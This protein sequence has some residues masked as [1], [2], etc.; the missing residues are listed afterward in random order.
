MIWMK[1]TNEQ[2]ELSTIWYD[3]IV[4]GK[5]TSQ[6]RFGEAK[7]K[8]IENVLNI[9]AEIKANSLDRDLIVMSTL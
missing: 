1:S 9:M 4:E 7:H 2:P 5:V 6:P 3:V 8:N